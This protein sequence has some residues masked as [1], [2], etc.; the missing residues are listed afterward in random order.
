MIFSGFIFCSLLNLTVIIYDFISE[1]GLNPKGSEVR[2]MGDFEELLRKNMPVLERFVRFRIGNAHDADD[3]LQE[4]CIAA[5]KN[6]DGLK[7]E[8]LFKP[9]LLGIARHKCN[10]YFREKAKCLEIP[11]DELHESALSYGAHGVT[12]ASVVRETLDLL[13]DKDKQI[14]YLYYFKELPQDE[15]GKRL[16]M[17]LGTVKSRLHNAKQRFKEKYPYKPKGENTMKQLPEIMPEYRI[18]KSEDKPFETIHRELPGMFIIPA[19]NE[20]IVFGMYDLPDRKLSGQYELKVTGKVN[21]H[22]IEGVE[23]KSHYQ[24]N[25][26][27]EER[28]IFAQL[29]DTNCRYL[30]GESISSG[31]RK[32]VTFLDEEFE[33]A[34]CIGEGNCGFP[35]KRKV[36]GRILQ[37]GDELFY[38]DQGEVSD[39]VGRFTIV[40]GKKEYDVVRLVDIQK[41]NGGVML[42]EYYLDSAG[43]TVL[44]RRFNND[45]WAFSRYKKKWTE[46]LPDSERLTVNG[47]TY[48]HWYDCI[49]DYIL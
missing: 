1:T 9:W 26:V 2:V 35:V 14:L 40:L 42:C 30:G 36:E 22:G 13:G 39:L 18:T 34:Y 29:T 31:C 46:M 23:I 24:E 19:E 8:S 7:D 33:N 17:P 41:S 20:K 3:V 44:E 16:G 21:I 6:F 47:E 38:D 10:D 43:R 4:T 27:D 32:I 49:T 11:I 48:V 15:I 28:V 5:F 12:T 45:D 37:K 25:G